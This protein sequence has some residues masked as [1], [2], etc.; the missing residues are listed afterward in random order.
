MGMPVFFRYRKRFAR[1]ADL[2]NN[3]TINNIRGLGMTSSGKWCLLIDGMDTDTF[4]RLWRP[5]V[6]LCGG[7]V[8]LRPV[9][10]R[11]SRRGAWLDERLM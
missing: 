7:R 6:P 4:D 3:V 10:V 1:H 11:H 8:W 2:R 5:A 9:F